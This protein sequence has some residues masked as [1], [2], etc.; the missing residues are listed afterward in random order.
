MIYVSPDRLISGHIVCHSGK[1][2]ISTDD[3]RE[4]V[5]YSVIITHL[6]HFLT[7]ITAQSICQIFNI[8]SY[9]CSN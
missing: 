1:I 8:I 6:G 4:Q 5:N 2:R 9:Y 7:H 3:F